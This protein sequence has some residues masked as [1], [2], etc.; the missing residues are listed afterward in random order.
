ML[1]IWQVV[2]LNVLVSVWAWLSHGGAEALGHMNAAPRSLC[3][4]KGGL[5]SGPWGVEPRA[6]CSKVVPSLPLVSHCCSM[7]LE[8]GEP[9]V[10]GAF[11]PQCHLPLC[12]GMSWTWCCNNRTSD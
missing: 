4:L 8:S 2:I 10:Q 7:L 11:K 1:V 9:P 3:L 5:S 12:F 6:E